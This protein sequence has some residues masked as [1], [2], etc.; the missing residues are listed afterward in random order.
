MGSRRLGGAG[1]VLTPALAPSLA[2]EWTPSRAKMYSLGGD[3]YVFK[4]RRWGDFGQ[5]FEFCADLGGK[6]TF[7][8]MLAEIGPGNG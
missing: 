3:V 7:L 6:C 1:A 8:K 4:G 5:I 2:A